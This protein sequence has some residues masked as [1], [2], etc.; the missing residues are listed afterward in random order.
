MSKKKSKI[1]F[2]KRIFYMITVM[3]VVIVVYSM[4]LMWYTKD[5]TALAYLIPAVFAEMATAT[6]FYYSKAKKENEIKLANKYGKGIL[7]SETSD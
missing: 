6:G 1:E 4:A 7:D 5:S 3:T 2:S